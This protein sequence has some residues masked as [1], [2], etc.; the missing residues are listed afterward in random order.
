MPKL[1]EKRRGVLQIA[2]DGEASWEDREGKFPGVYVGGAH[3]L[4]LEKYG[5]NLWDAASFTTAEKAGLITGW[6]ERRMIRLT[7]AG[8]AALESSQS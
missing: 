1:S 3:P 6:A 8:R 5:L 2:Y 4:F 7:D